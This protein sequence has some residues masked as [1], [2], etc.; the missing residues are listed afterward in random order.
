[1]KGVIIVI[2]ILGSSNGIVT[3][4]EE[5]GWRRRDKPSMMTSHMQGTVPGMPCALTPHISLIIWLSVVKP[6]H[7]W[8]N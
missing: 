8:E 1:M 3:E 7:R 6:T 5:E 4:A 2:E